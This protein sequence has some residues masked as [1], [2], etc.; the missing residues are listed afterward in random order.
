MKAELAN[1]RTSPYQGLAPYAEQDAPYFFG[2][3]KEMRLIIAHFFAS[4]VTLLYGPSGVGKS[5][6]LRAG[7]I[8]ALRRRRSASLVMHNDWHGHAAKSLKQTIVKTA[9]TES[10]VLNVTLDDRNLTLS[11]L[12]QIYSEKVR[13]RVMVILDQFEEY[14]LRQSPASFDEELIEAMASPRLRANFLIS[15][16]EDAL[17]HMDRYASLFPRLFD[18]Y[19]RL[20]HLETKSAERAIRKPIAQFNKRFREPSERYTIDPRL[21]ELVLEQVKREKPY[22]AYN[23]ERNHNDLPPTAGDSIRVETA[24][25]QLVMLKLWN[26]EIERG[27]RILGTDTLNT[28]GNIDSIVFDHVSGIMDS[29]GVE[30]QEIAARLLKHLITISRRKIAHNSL[31]LALLSGVSEDQVRRVLNSMASADARI[32]RRLA[33]PDHPNQELF[34]V[35]HDVL[36]EPLLKWMEK[37]AASSKFTITDRASEVW[38]QSTRDADSIRKSSEEAKAQA[39]RSPFQNQALLYD[40]RRKR[41][42]HPEFDYWSDSAISRGYRAST[43]SIEMGDSST[44]A[45]ASPRGIELL[46]DCLVNCNVR[47]LDY[48]DKSY[49]AGVR[50]RGSLPDFRFGYLAYLRVDGQLELYRAQEI[51]ASSNELMGRARLSEWI[52]LQVQILHSRVEV[53][54]NDVVRISVQDKM[55]GGTGRVYLHTFGTRAEF[56]NLRIYKLT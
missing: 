56:G 10:N 9:L 21:V 43:D 22:D 46:E 5:S 45:T 8:P 36:G 31:D 55:F 13:R 16:R 44:A 11:E 23:I 4:P 49:W 14:L 17:A 26:E 37:Q 18:S 20:D 28:I 53:L 51:I 30:D 2:R 41:G 50:V 33:S 42:I 48:S 29:L 12:L 47:I 3:E 1:Q 7:V 15:F 6:I 27:S 54:V 34:E 19:L 38:S 40:I 39:Q 24:Y 32:L 25:L 52:H 35:Y